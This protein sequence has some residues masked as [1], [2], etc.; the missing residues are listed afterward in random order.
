MIHIAL[1]RQAFLRAVMFLK[2]NCPG[3]DLEPLSTCPSRNH[4]ANKNHVFS[5]LVY[6][7]SHKKFLALQDMCSYADTHTHTITLAYM[8][9]QCFL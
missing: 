1:W 9:M 5:P 8:D 3:L 6:S 4:M 7:P 2:R